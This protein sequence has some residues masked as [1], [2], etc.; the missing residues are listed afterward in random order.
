MTTPLQDL[1]QAL[2]E[3]YV[4]VKEIGRGGMATV[5][6]ARDPEDDTPVAVKVLEPE[7]AGSVGAQRFLREIRITAQLDHPGILTLYDSGESDGTLYYVMPYVEG[8]SLGGRMKRDRQLSIDEAIKIVL[9]VSDAL[10]Y[11]HDLG[12]VHRDIKPEN[13][14]LSGDRVMLSD[15][16][17]ARAVD[18]AVADKLTETGLAVGTPHYMS[19]EQWMGDKVDGRSDIYA[20]GCVLYEMLVGEPPF[21]GASAPVILARHAMEALPSMRVARA[22]ISPGV[23]AVVRKAMAKVPADRYATAGAFAAALRAA[24]R[25]ATA[26]EQS[27][28]RATGTSAEPSPVAARISLARWAI[29]AALS[30]LL[31]VGGYFGWSAIAGGASGDGTRL[32][33]LPFRNVGAAEDEYFTEGI[34]EEITSRLS[35]VGS[36]G[37]IARTSAAQYRNSSKSVAEIGEELGVSYLLEGSVRWNRAGSS[38]PGVRITVGLIKVSDLTQT[39]VYEGE[40]EL[41]QVFA[42]QAGVAESVVRA[43][44]VALPGPE[45]ARLAAV[46][47]DNLTAYDF[48]LRGNSYYNR[49]WERLDVDSAALMYQRATE[50]DPGYALAWAQLGKTHTWIHRLGYD[51]TPERLALARSAINKAKEFGPNL[52]ET[53]IAQG[54]YHYWGEWDYEKAIDALTAARQIQPSNAWVYLQLGNIRRRKGEWVQAAQDYE[55]AGEFDPRFHIIWFNLGHLHQHI[56][57]YDLAETY[58]NRAITLQ[59][60]FVDAYLLKAALQVSRSGDTATARQLFDSVATIVPPDRWRPLYGHWLMGAARLYDSPAERLQ[61][62]VP[63]RFGLDSSMYLLARAEA[64]GDL[65]QRA[66]ARATL[67]SSIVVLESVYTET[68]GVAW[69]SGALGVAYALRGE[70]GKAIAAAKRAQLL[71]SDAL[72]GPSWIINEARVQTLL[73][74]RKEALDALDLALRIPSGL[75]SHWLRLDPAWDPL[76]GDPRFEQLIKRGSPAPPP[77]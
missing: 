29:L 34:T 67:D 30:V 44:N 27:S 28:G 73:G 33:V 17:I 61:M 74:N 6:L 15:F 45:K 39:K 54:L 9:E 19:P 42:V 1:Q 43:L 52:A 38:I 71:M 2:G 31:G 7:L 77:A 16:G 13:I 53:H 37:V 72:D 48:Y 36:I 63:G 62:A 55:R 4:V 76:R 49:S 56:R 5:Y 47:T 24:P 50:L 11:A 12:F 18:Q 46:P 26:A 23:E 66:A 20:L 10:E 75:T 59:P 64:L 25:E 68:P 22:N 58:L 69:I 65:G 21:S 35:G 51:E 57:Q 32:V 41:A 8:E 14:L 70:K 3:R 40:F 60:T